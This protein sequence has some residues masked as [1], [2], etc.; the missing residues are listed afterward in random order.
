MNNNPRKKQLNINGPAKKVDFSSV[1]YT[2]I[3]SSVDDDPIISNLNKYINLPSFSGIDRL[4]HNNNVRK[5]K[6]IKVTEFLDYYLK[7]DPIEKNGKEVQTSLVK[8]SLDLRSIEFGGK[9]IAI[10]DDLLIKEFG[11]SGQAE[12]REALD[13]QQAELNKVIVANRDAVITHWAIN[14]H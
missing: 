2:H 12:L 13:E 4:F 1:N 9:A 8:L 6:Q 5:R 14:R 7:L 10:V 3:I 11:R